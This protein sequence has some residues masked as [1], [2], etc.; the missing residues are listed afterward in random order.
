MA[1]QSQ[2]ERE[3]LT[4]K[5]IEEIEDLF[6][7]YLKQLAEFKEQIRKA[8]APIEV[9]SMKTLRLGLHNVNVGFM[10][11]QEAIQE[12]RFWPDFNHESK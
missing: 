6:N 12:Q 8:K 9:R 5:Q 11:I 7:H 3:Q 10:R 4:D 1:K 2:R